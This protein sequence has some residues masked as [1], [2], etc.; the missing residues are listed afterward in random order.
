MTPKRTPKRTKSPTP[1]ARKGCQTRP[2]APSVAAL[3]AAVD[4]VAAPSTPSRNYDRDLLMAFAEWLGANPSFCRLPV[5]EVPV[6]SVWEFLANLRVRR[7]EDSD[8]LDPET[9]AAAFAAVDDAMA[10]YR[11][12]RARTP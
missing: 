4:R 1:G 3:D 9:M 8:Y 2:S 11:A 6:R 12:K 7:P 5:G 10:E